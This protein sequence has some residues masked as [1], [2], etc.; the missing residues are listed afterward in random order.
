MRHGTGGPLLS[1]TRERHT[2]QGGRS[3]TYWGRWVT[4]AEACAWWQPR[5]AENKRQSIKRC[6]CDEV[7]STTPCLGEVGTYK[8]LTILAW[9]RENSGFMTSQKEG[10][11][12]G[13]RRRPMRATRRGGRGNHPAVG[14]VCRSTLLRLSESTTTRQD[15]SVDSIDSI[16]S[17]KPRAP[18][19]NPLT[20]SIDK[21]LILT[22]FPSN[23]SF[24]NYIVINRCHHVTVDRINTRRHSS[25]YQHGRDERVTHM[26]RAWGHTRKYETKTKLVVRTSYMLSTHVTIE[27]KR[28][29]LWHAVSYL[30]GTKNAAEFQNR[31]DRRIFKNS[32][33]HTC[34]PKR[35]PKPR[36]RS[37]KTCCHGGRALEARKRA[38]HNGSHKIHSSPSKRGN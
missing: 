20:W 25:R 11:R 18:T 37:N 32:V 10:Y 14:H 19:S 3:C 4:P 2:V 5:R 34:V 31:H 7:R 35:S 28:K 24:V 8:A 38:K 36:S 9:L 1:G 27:V 16:D 12:A 29:D 30:V 26:R 17:M 13:S 21:S 33:K 6:C 22:G 23:A 15:P